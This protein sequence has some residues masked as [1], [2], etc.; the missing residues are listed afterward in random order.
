MLLVA[1]DALATYPALV[2]NVAQIAGSASVASVQ[3]SIFGMQ[4]K[5]TNYGIKP[6]I[7]VVME[8]TVFG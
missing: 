2:S 4:L 7:Q 8:S 5:V 6:K 1:V 3:P